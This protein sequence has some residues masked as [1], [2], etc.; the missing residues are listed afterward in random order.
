MLKSFRLRTALA[1]LVSTSIASSL[2]CI[3]Y[4]LLSE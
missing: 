4:Y 1:T 2:L 3:R